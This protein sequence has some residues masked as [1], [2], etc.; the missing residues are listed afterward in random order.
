MQTLVAEGFLELCVSE[1]KGR[2]VGEAEEEEEPVWS[3]PQ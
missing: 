2:E 1:S 3:V